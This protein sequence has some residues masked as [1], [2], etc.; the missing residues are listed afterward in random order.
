[1]PQL[2]IGLFCGEYDFARN[3]NIICG[4][5]KWEESNIFIN[6]LFFT[7]NFRI[8]CKWCTIDRISV[9][10]YNHVTK[11]CSE[12]RLPYRDGSGIV[13]IVTFIIIIMV[14]IKDISKKTNVSPATVSKALNGYKDVSPDT[15]ERIKQVAI[16]MNYLPNTAAQQLKTNVSH[17]IGVLFVDDS[18][19]GLTHEYFSGILNSAKDELEHLGYDIT[20]ISQNVG[21]RHASF[22]EHALYRNCDGVLI[23]CVDFDSRQVREII[24]SDIPTVAIDYSYEGISSVMSDN[25]EGGYELTKF[26][27]ER[28]HRKIAFIQGDETI[29]T[30]KRLNGYRR[31]FREAFLPVPE[32]LMLKGAFHDARKSAE[33]TAKLMERKERPTAIMYPDDFSYLG[34]ITELERMGVS[35]PDEVSATG[36]D[37][38]RMGQFLRPRPTTYYQDSDRI[39]RLSAKKL[40]ET[41]EEGD[42]CVPEQLIVKGKLIEG[43]TVKAVTSGA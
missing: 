42:N 38:I 36:Y 28:G 13:E 43:D 14:T 5:S 18:Q 32:S 6:S 3:S 31:A 10:T 1:M 35:I 39:G 30:R 33:L 25:V 29:V 19:C 41:I 40:V 12:S 2:V 16:E 20:F 21:G 27:L 37:G 26:L 9:T 7:K 11:S 15:A 17:N 23:A 34:G 22:L 4:K 8:Y 24:E